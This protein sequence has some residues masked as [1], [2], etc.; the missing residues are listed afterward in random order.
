MN[1]DLLFIADLSLRI[2]LALQFLVLIYVTVLL[3]EIR[4]YI[5][6][7]GDVFADRSL[8]PVEIVTQEEQKRDRL[9]N[10]VLEHII[11]RAAYHQQRI[12]KNGPVIDP[13]RST[14]SILPETDRQ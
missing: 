2:I 6:P 13:E 5:K 11:S 10:Q 9:Y 1:W 12:S 8:E 14:S 3:S 7:L 4:N